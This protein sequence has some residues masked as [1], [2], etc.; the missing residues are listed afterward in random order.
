MSATATHTST[1]STSAL[2]G[3]AAFLA[4]LASVAGVLVLPAVRPAEGRVEAA[5]IVHVSTAG[6]DSSDGSSQSPVRTVKRAV[7]LARAGDTVQIRTGTYHEEVHVY[8]KQVHIE[9]APGADVVFDGARPVAGWS[10]VNNGWAA[11]WNTDFSRAGAPHTTAERPEAG[12]P[13][14]FFIDGA[15]GIGRAIW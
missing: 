8:A 12:W 1:F 14:Q 15:S 3:A 9:A 4:S 7:Q 2:R 10:R 5:S 6:S 13:E 11:Q